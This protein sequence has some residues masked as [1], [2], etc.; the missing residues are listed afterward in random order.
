MKKQF[1]ETG[2]SL[3]YRP[4]LAVVVTASLFVTACN[5]NSAVQKTSDAIVTPPG[6]QSA[7]L[8]TIG[9][10]DFITLFPTAGNTSY[11]S[12]R[13]PS[14]IKSKNGV[15]IAACE[16]RKVDGDAG[17]IDVVVRR[18]LKNSDGTYQSGI[19]ASQ[20]TTQKIVAGFTSITIA[21]IPA[22]GPAQPDSK[23]GTWGNPTMV[24]DQSNGRVWLFMNYNDKDHSQQGGGGFL[25]IDSYGERRTF[26]CYSD[27]DGAN[28]STPA[29]L[30]LDVT[31]NTFDWDA[32]GPG[33]GIQKHFGATT[34]RL[35]IPALKRNIYSDDHGAHWTSSPVPSSL[36]T[37]E[38]TI[39]E[40]LNGTLYR[41]DRPAPK[42][43][44]SVSYRR[45]SYGD[46]GSWTSAF[47]NNTLLPDPACQGSILRY[48]ESKPNR[49]YFM[50][51]A[52]Q[53]Q[54]RHPKIRITYDEGATWERSRDIPESGNGTTTILGGYS[55]LVKTGDNMTGLL[56][57]FNNNGPMTLQ[58]HK[59]S[60][61]WILNGQ[62]EPTGY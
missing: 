51:S 53:T 59:F 43:E 24:V 40:K 16:A 25:P 18:L 48:T 31:P 8:A 28:W 11:T 20:W 62:T 47:T 55:S 33:I 17:D 10:Y 1:V 36:G 57:E 61:T 5:K 27:D 37:S 12:Y 2:R 58:Y 30:T 13:I 29:D 21:P 7:S 45:T 9:I 60:L 46:I 22:G 49:I 39:V 56:I 41:N 3:F 38:S 32:A 14:I 54:R 35:I 26:A 6:D 34:G 50:N 44:A 42:P 23:L 15:L 19:V 52:S 4:F